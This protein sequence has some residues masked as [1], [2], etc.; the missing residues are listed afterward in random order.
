MGKCIVV[1]DFGQGKTKISA[2]RKEDGK[3]TMFSGSVFNTPDGG[4]GEPELLQMLSVQLEKMELGRGS[5]LVLLPADEKNSIVGEA[6]Y[7]MGTP[8]EV[9]SIIK[10]N[11]SSFIPDEGEL[12]HYDW[13]LTEAYPSGHG[14]FQIAAVRLADIETIHDIAERKKL[15]LIRA[16]VTPN[17]IEAAATLLRGDKKYGLATAED[18]I[19]LVD[20]GHKSAQIA[21]ISRDRTVKCQVLRHDLYRM[22]KL[23]IGSLGDLK[24][25]KTIVPEL[26]KLNPTY[27][28]KVS[29]YDGFMESAAA[30]I[31][32]TIKQAVSGES[33]YRL[34]TVYFT[35][36]LYKMPG[37]VG[38]V[39]DSF[40]VP[41]F[42]YPIGDFV[43]FK[44]NSIK[45][46]AK[47][48]VPV[49]D[50]F[51]ASV[52]ALVGGNLLCK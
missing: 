12:Y 33:R 7:P 48:A 25:D 52:G 14:H 21:V 41:C 8:K 11:I 9:A 35:G 13:R 39:K 29:Q 45:H 31:V 18:A 34:T 37:L 20:V 27:T 22:D 36:G 30:D 38:Y 15:A 47:K 6:D 42:A 51:T 32:R 43:Q 19:A 5:L 3:M 28:Q 26:L 50:I 40:G 16:G 49:P 1:V 24:N 17:A 46:E 2:Y 23:I 10:N 4:L 44:D